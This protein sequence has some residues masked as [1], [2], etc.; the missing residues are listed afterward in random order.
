M[1]KGRMTENS[2][3]LRMKVFDTLPSFDRV[4]INMV[5]INNDLVNNYR[6]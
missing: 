1:I 6:N 2:D 4:G 5:E 3:L